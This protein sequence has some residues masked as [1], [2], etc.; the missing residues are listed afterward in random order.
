MVLAVLYLSKSGIITRGPLYRVF[1]VCAIVSSHSKYTFG[2]SGLNR[3]S[4]K[5][6]TFRSC[7]ELLVANV[8][9][10]ASV[11]LVYSNVA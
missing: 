8:Q 6:K 7:N 3:D 5:K 4:V 10:A 11:M 2:L 1:A 9:M